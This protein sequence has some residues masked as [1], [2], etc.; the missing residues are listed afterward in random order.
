MKKNR[1]K[2]QFN[3]ALKNSTPWDE[4]ELHDKKEVYEIFG[5]TLK[6][7]EDEKFIN[8]ITENIR[9]GSLVSIAIIL[10]DDTPQAQGAMGMLSIFV[11]HSV[12]VEIISTYDMVKYL[13]LALRDDEELMVMVNQLRMLLD[14]FIPR[15]KT[16]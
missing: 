16:D 12:G 5:Y 11:K 1:T 10:T 13:N 9:V 14:D 4:L 15:I 8:D 6:D 7:V 3:E 2:K